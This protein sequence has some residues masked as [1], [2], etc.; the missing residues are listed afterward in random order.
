VRGRDRLHDG[1]AEAASGGL[2]AV[3]PGPVA[4]GHA[5]AAAA[6][7]EAVEGPRRVLLGH[8]GTVVADL[9]HR[10]VAV[11]VEA[12][13]GGGARRGVRADVAEQ[14]REH[15][16]D[17]RLV[18]GD[19]QA[20]RDLRPHLALRFDRSR[21]G[22]RVPGQQGEVGL[23][24]VEGRHAVEAGQFEQFG[25]EHAHPVGFLLDA[26]HRVRQVGGAERALPVQL[27][28]PADRGQRGAQLVGGVGGELAHLLF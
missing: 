26:P 21:V 13:G 1:Q 20:G 24:Q 14:V 11:R 28:V 6:A 22:H 25:D 9:E 23:G 19:H 10:A 27:G 7:V 3:V 12:D 15:L 18:G 17:S 2:G 5:V 4:A 8:A 16:A